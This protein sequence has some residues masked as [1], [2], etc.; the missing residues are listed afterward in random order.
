MARG[1]E[2]SVFALTWNGQN[3]ALAVLWAMGGLAWGALIWWC[4]GRI[5]PEERDRT[6]D[7]RRPCLM[8]V[9]TVTALAAFATRVT[10][11]NLAVFVVVTSTLLAV[12]LVD[13]R[14]RIIPDTVLLAGTLMLLV[15]WG[16]AGTALAAGGFHIAGKDAAVLSARHIG[17]GL[18]GAFLLGGVLF[19][20]HLASA[21]R[22]M[23]MGDVKLAAFIG[24]VLGPV[25]GMWALLWGAVAGAIAALVALVFHWRAIGDAIPY[26][27]FLSLG[28]ILLLLASGT[29]LV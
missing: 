5:V 16:A 17:S 8:A 1:R 9:T 10:G 26:G 21:G 20:I 12:S 15:L 18:A 7:W 3:P 29:V 13:V 11:W 2:E 22:G 27:P 19:A 4:I 25:T 24:F 14:H 6:R 23:G 28:A